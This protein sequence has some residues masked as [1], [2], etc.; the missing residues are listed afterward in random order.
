MLKEILLKEPMLKYRKPEQSYIL[1]ID[2]SKYAWAGVWTQSFAYEEDGKEY[3]IHHPITYVSG[4]FRGP[5]I[6]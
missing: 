2:A 6:E 1:Y 4:L 5:Q 3:F